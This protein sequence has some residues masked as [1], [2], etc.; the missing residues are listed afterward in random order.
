MAG[1][2]PVCSICPSRMSLLF[3]GRD[4]RQ[5]FLSQATQPVSSRA[6]MS[7]EFFTALFLPQ[8][9]HSHP[10]PQ[11]T[12]TYIT[13]TRDFNWKN[14]KTLSSLKNTNIE[15]SGKKS[16]QEAMNLGGFLRSRRGLLYEWVTDFRASQP[17]L[18][19][20]PFGKLSSKSRISQGQKSRIQNYLLAWRR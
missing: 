5:R 17:M 11:R 20:L 16:K 2:P 12:H 4:L 19:P 6:E 15:D 8:E 1:V 3:R 13:H 14:Q 9:A 10:L 18:H 7:L